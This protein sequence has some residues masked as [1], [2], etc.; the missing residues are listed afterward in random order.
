M[1]FHFQPHTAKE[2]AQLDSI[3]PSRFF[4]SESEADNAPANA[5]FGGCPSGGLMSGQFG[6][7]TSEI[8]RKK[9]L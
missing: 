9:Y 8:P 3:F 5:K 4:L 7:K 6:S 1:L 2:I